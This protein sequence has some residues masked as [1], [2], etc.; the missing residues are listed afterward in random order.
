MN[1][2][3]LVVDDDETLGHLFVQVLARMKIDSDFVNNPRLALE[4]FKKGNFS[5][6][7]TD[8]EMHSDSTAGLKLILEIRKLNPAIPIIM[9]SGKTD[10]QIRALGIQH[11]ANH[12]LHK[13]HD[14][15]KL[16]AVIQEE[17]EAT[18]K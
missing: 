7:L 10:D 3:V 2:K 9:I 17:I 8:L 6:V 14:L 1:T 11:G 16:G 4:V 5:L 13:L 15:D 12:V 18:M